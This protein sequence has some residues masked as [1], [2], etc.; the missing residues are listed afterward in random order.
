MEP[1]TTTN[2]QTAA[3]QGIY[4]MLK[5]P[6]TEYCSSLDSFSPDY[7]FD[8]LFNESDC[9]INLEESPVHDYL[10]DQEI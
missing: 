6:V 9:Q 7:Q 8:E 3:Q 1:I 4:S 5:P 2:K 10:L